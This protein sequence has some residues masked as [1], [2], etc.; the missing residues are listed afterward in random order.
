MRG[1]ITVSGGS[2]HRGGASRISGHLCF[3]SEK[4]M[5]GKRMD[6]VE[7]GVGMD[8]DR[9]RVAEERGGE[10]GAEGREE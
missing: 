5:L 8:Q 6:R 3:I 4:V 9:S 1:I 10:G 7:W 2:L